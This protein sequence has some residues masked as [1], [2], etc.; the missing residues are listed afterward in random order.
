MNSIHRMPE[1]DKPSPL[2]PK[3]NSFVPATPELDKP[4]QQM[5]STC[6]MPEPDTP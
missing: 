2:P 6:R 5:N 1:Q 4:S 3:L